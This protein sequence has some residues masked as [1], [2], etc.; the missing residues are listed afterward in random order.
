MNSCTILN[1]CQY[2]FR[3]GISTSH[4]LV[5]FLDDITHPLE[6]KKCAIGIFIA[7]KKAFDTVDHQLLCKKVYGIRGNA[8]NWTSSYLNNRSQFVD[9]DGHS[10]GAHRVTCG[11]PQGSVL[12][13]KLFIL[14]I[15]DMCN[16]SKL[17]KCILFADDTNIFYSA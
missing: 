4:A 6:Y 5:E 1:S 13:P 12:G 11:V 8:Y 3:E 16:V 17:V 2:G 7:L 9:I 15:N 14:Y 10:S